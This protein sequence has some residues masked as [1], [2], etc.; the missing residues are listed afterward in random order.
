MFFSTI[1]SHIFKCLADMLSVFLDLYSE[2]EQFRFFIFRYYDR[3]GLKTCDEVCEESFVEC[4]K[5]PLLIEHYYVILITLYYN[6]K[7]IYLDT[8]LRVYFQNISYLA[9][10]M[11]ANCSV[12]YK[13]ITEILEI[14][15]APTLRCLGNF[16][17]VYNRII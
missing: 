9:A 4:I 14:N 17:F 15:S 5:Y 7:L 16:V 12:R 1:H 10:R 13:K 3:N 2:T 6:V 8:T 11:I